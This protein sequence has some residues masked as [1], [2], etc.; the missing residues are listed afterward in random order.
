MKSGGQA[1]A[2]RSDS[3]PRGRLYIRGPEEAVNETGSARH[4]VRSAKK[5]GGTF[6][7]EKERELRTSRQHESCNPK[8]AK[9]GA[10]G[11]FLLSAGRTAFVSDG[12]TP[13][14]Q[15]GNAKCIDDLS[16]GDQQWMLFS[17]LNPC[18]AGRRGVRI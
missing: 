12:K 17:C 2:R 3:L 7:R 5:V 10:S 14:V 4:P 6:G 1:G 11:S 18:S 9:N 16:E 15:A 13:A 8:D